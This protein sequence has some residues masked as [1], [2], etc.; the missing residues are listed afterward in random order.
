MKQW[1][2]LLLVAYVFNVYIFMRNVFFESGDSEVF[3][4]DILSCLQVMTSKLTIILPCLTCFTQTCQLCIPAIVEVFS[5]IFF[6]M[7]VVLC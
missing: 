3:K 7:A 4:T 6:G 2:N 5:K 1:K